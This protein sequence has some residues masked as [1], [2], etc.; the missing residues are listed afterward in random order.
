MTAAQIFS[1]LTNVS[2]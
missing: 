1:N 2:N